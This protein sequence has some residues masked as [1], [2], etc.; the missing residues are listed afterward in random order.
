M[1]DKPIAI[2]EVQTVSPGLQSAAIEAGKMPA[3]PGAQ[4]GLLSILLATGARNAPIRF[5]CCAC[6]SVPEQVN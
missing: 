6:F 3:L 4:P 5:P 1:D 2:A